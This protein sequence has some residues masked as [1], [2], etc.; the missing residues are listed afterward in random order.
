MKYLYAEQTR[1]D[2]SIPQPGRIVGDVPARY[3]GYPAEGIRIFG[4]AKPRRSNCARVSLSWGIPSSYE[5]LTDAIQRGLYCPCICA[6]LYLLTTKLASN[7]RTTAQE[8]LPS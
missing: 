7:L 2:R 3:R 1:R 5:I 6:V 8:I 4:I